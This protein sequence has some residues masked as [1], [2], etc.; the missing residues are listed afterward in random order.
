[1]EIFRADQSR[2]IWLEDE[3]RSIGKVRVPD[4]FWWRMRESPA[5]FLDV[6]REK[7]A[8]NLVGEYGELDRT[9][10]RDAVT[11]LAKKLGGLRVRQF[12][13]LVERGDDF[14]VALGLLEYYDKSYGHA[15]EK[16]PREQVF[17][18][19]GDST[20]ES[21]VEFSRTLKVAG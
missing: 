14:A 2:P 8:Q 7:R 3:S 19:P 1:M 21:I 18:L 17:R 10:L 16:R 20:S 6:A 12:C 9:A 11:R 5:I 15:A 4:S 13:E